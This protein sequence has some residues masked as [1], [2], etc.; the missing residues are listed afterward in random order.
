MKLKALILAI[1]FSVTCC[2]A[3]TYKVSPNGAV[4]RTSLYTNYR[5][6]TYT[7]NT[8]AVSYV[9][10]VMDFSGS[11]NAW[12]QEAKRAMTKIVSAI[13]SNINVGF[14]VF[15]QDISSTKNIAQTA[16]S[17]QKK[18]TSYVVKAQT[19]MNACSA[20]TQV[21]PISG[22]NSSRLISGMN[23]VNLGGAT[24]M[25]YAL[26]KTV[27]QDF[28]PLPA[29]APKK[30]I[31]I[32]DGGENCGGDPCAFARNLNRSD[33]QIDVVLVSS[34]SRA[35]TC[36]TSETGGNFYTLNNVSELTN[37]LKKSITSE[38]TSEPQQNY[39]F[40]ND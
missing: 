34:N 31:L 26:E 35:L 23:S 20:S 10:I 16:L 29:S 17:V 15:G 7:P 38:S 33:I 32:T 28:A 3:A 5:S 19:P 14:R 21:A 11:M 40:I 22:F 12:V 8:S 24:P 37:T 6:T 4:N 18:G 9:E 27:Y 1:I 39:E 30:I 13:P 36:V 2:M 25:V